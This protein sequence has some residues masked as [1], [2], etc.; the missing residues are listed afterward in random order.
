MSSITTQ[1]NYSSFI[2]ECRFFFCQK[3]FEGQW[4]GKEKYIVASD[5]PEDELLKKY[6]EIMKAL[7]PYVFCNAAC[8][9]VYAESVKNM[10]KFI[11][12]SKSTISFGE[13]EVLENQ[14]AYNEADNESQE[15][16]KE[17]L[18]ICTPLQRERIIKYYIEGK[19]L[20]QI[21]NGKNIANVQQS[22]Q[23]GLKKIKK[24]FES[25]T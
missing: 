8:G 7:S 15:L 20:R 19:N 18:S 22:I 13:I 17:G 11:K 1:K 23:T 9:D 16:I 24:Y 3:L 2:R 5:T 6:P 25:D 14:I 4:E 21:A 12:R 10:D